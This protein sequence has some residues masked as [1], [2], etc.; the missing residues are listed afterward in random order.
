MNK[1]LLGEEHPY[2]A[3]GLNNLA[4]LYRLQ[5][6]YSE[7]EPL[8]QQA[9]EMSRNLLGEDHPNTKIFYNNLLNLREKLKQSE[10]LSE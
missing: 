4:G 1:K 10:N 2:V 9:L 7:A 6:R 5:G 3:D 8:Y